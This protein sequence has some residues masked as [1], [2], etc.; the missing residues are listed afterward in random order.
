MLTYFGAQSI[1]GS[2]D[3]KKL[4]NNTYL[5]RCDLGDGYFA[6]VLH[7]T[8]VVKIY[9]DGTYVL[10]SGGWLTLTTRKRINKYSPAFIWQKNFTWFLASYLDEK[11]EFFD[12]V[13][14][15]STGHVVT[16]Q[17]VTA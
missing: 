12:G 3:R 11:T 17:A 10:S 5:E 15:D 4:E 13:R 14:V 6:V 8:E 7:R 9:R 1:L 2:R 16:A